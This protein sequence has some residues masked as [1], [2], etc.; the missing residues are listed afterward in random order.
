MHS[1]KWFDA[2]LKG[3]WKEA[4]TGMINL[5][6]E[7]PMI[8]EVFAKLVEGALDPFEIFREAELGLNNCPIKIATKV[9]IFGDFYD[10]PQLQ[11]QGMHKLLRW[12]NLERG[13][14]CTPSYMP[15]KLAYDSTS[16]VAKLRTFFADVCAARFDKKEYK[17]YRKIHPSEFVDD[18]ADA[19]MDMRP[20]EPK[21]I[22]SR[23]YEPIG[24]VISTIR[25]GLNK[26]LCLYVETG[27]SW[28]S[29]A[30]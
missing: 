29:Q 25:I 7:D 30:R 2:M 16:E 18:Y 6:E 3:Q 24:P 8:F 20:S 9:W 14:Y 17:Q 10:A 15:I 13:K 22:E 4:K 12:C 1:S 26:R 19:L 28:K 27:A 21:L 5:K 11:N 23:Y